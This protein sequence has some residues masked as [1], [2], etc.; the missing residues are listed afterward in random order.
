M[1]EFAD[2]CFEKALR[3]LW[4]QLRKFCKGN[5]IK[6]LVGGFSLTSLGSPSSV[7]FPELGST[8]K[9]S[10]VKIIT[11]FVAEVSYLQDR[12]RPHSSTRNMN[13]WSFADLQ[14]VLDHAGQFLDDEQLSRS[15]HA[16]N[17]YLWSYSVLAD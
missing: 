6:P 11:A 9:A 1:I 16:A 12:G 8:Y 2:E 14:F 17:V 5:S 10:A 15:I 7:A 13:S 3:Q 4:F